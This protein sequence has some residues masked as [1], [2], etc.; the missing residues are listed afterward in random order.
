MLICG[1]RDKLIRLFDVREKLCKPLYS[2]AG[3]EQE[4][5]GLKFSPDNKFIASGGNDN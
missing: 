5:C 2:F 4:I 1:S 3:H